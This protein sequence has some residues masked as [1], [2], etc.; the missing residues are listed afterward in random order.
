MVRIDTAILLDR[1]LVRTGVGDVRGD[2]PIGEAA[3][4]GPRVDVVFEFPGPEVPADGGLAG[5]VGGEGGVLRFEEFAEPGAFVLVLF[6]VSR[7]VGC[8]ACAEAPFADES[9]GD[10]AAVADLLAEVADVL[11][12][13][14]FGQVVEG[15]EGPELMRVDYEM[16]GGFLGVGVVG[17]V[18]CPGVR[19]VETICA[20][21][22]ISISGEFC[23]GVRFK[24]TVDG[25]VD[26]SDIDNFRAWLV[27]VLEVFKAQ[28]GFI[29]RLDIC[30]NV[31]KEL[32]D[33][34]V[35]VW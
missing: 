15:W 3:A 7:R 24:H 17:V 34:H 13:L 4:V 5:V 20:G 28:E 19:V 16:G 31:N 30:L 23:K 25:E 12:G 9:V 14:E 26:A 32:M 10:G 6:R 1:I 22:G 29:K 21:R 11:D 8:D 35:L 27:K 18:V 33:S 2:V